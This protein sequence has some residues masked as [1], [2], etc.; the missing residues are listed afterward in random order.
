[1]SRSYLLL[2][3]ICNFIFPKDFN[4]MPI[5]YSQYESLGRDYS[6]S[7]K[8]VS[9]LG[10]GVKGVYQGGPISIDADFINHTFIG[11]YNKPN[12][13]SHD[14]GIAQFTKW[15]YQ[16]VKSIYDSRI[17]NMK[18]IY[19]GEDINL[20]FGKFNRN[21]GPGLSSLT[22]SNKS[23]SYPQIGFNWVINHKLRFEY[24]IGM[25]RSLI[26]D[27]LSTQYYTNPITTRHVDIK[28]NVVAHR[29]EYDLTPT[30]TLGGSESI[31]YALRDFDL[32]YF[33]FIAF[34]PMK[35][36]IGD[37]DNLQIGIDINWKPN[38]KSILYTTVFIDEMDPKYLLKKYSENWWGW[39]FG[40]QY[41]DFIMQSSR[42]RVEYTWMDHRVYRNKIV[43]NDYYHY[44]Y[45]LGFWGGPHS[46]EL[47]I[48]FSLKLQNLDIFLSYS[49]AKR[50]ELTDQMILNAYDS[51]NY[52]RYSGIVEQKQI[53][54]ITALKDIPA[55]I[56]F[57]VGIDVIDW[58][59]G[60]FEP[61]NRNTIET[62]KLQTI[63]KL[64]ISLGLY[65]NFTNNKIR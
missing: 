27:T 5:L 18:F 36:Y 29:F 28:R 60:G 43:L 57:L 12:S 53:L 54:S 21:W 30:L 25:L 7:L 42:I 45:P 24:F 62:S 22:F 14:Q 40:L 3:F 26:E 20:E 51:I 56:K 63:S 38:N 64:S 47:Y 8:P 55:N 11:L 41:K 2:I 16:D 65:Y 15:P 17:S 33:P 13:F 34:W 59:N 9:I 6:P 1:M 32:H 10:W 37:I 23:P 44:G 35:N 58:V 48:D 50:G 4:I 61:Y 46:E 39:Q 19:S 49:N 52:R 31:I